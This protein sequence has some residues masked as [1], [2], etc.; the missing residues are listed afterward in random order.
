MTCTDEVLGNWV[1]RAD[2]ATAKGLVILN[3]ADWADPEVSNRKRVPG[4]L[5]AVIL[6]NRTV[7]AKGTVAAVV[8][9]LTLV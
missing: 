7:G 5:V 1:H 4:T 3:G 2:Q 9:A 8:P 6:G